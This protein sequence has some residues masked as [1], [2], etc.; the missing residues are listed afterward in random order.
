MTTESQTIVEDG[1]EA[2]AAPDPE[3]ESVRAVFCPDDRATDGPWYV[4]LDTSWTHADSADAFHL[5]RLF[6]IVATQVSWLNV[7]MARK[8][9]EKWGRQSV[10]ASKMQ[11]TND[12]SLQRLTSQVEGSFSPNHPDI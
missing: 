1:F 11:L 5:A 2:I 6:Q 12:E 8:T 10:E 3:H 7:G 4:D 9:V